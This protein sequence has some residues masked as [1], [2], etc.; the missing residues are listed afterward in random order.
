[1]ASNIQPLQTS[2]TRPIAWPQSQAY[3]AGNR[4]S[5]W[6]RPSPLRNYLLSL[7]TNS[8][9]CSPRTIGVDICQTW[10][11]IVCPPTEEEKIAMS[12]FFHATKQHWKK[13]QP[14]LDQPTK[15]QQCPSVMCLQCCISIYCFTVKEDEFNKMISP[16]DWIHP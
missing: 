1:M 13:I 16:F 7:Q 6:E 3:P 4:S 5:S 8:S 12:I 14:A 2:D 11:V 9:L 10:Y 15:K